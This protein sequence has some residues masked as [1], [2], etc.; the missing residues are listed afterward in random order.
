MI[1]SELSQKTFS[2]RTKN[3][4]FYLTIVAFWCVIIIPTVLYSDIFPLDNEGIFNIGENFQHWL[5][6]IA[7]PYNG[8]GR[9][10]PIFWI[11]WSSQ[12][13]IFAQNIG[14]YLLVQGIFFLLG[15]IFFTN[16]LKRASSSKLAALTFSCFAIFSVPVAENITSIGKAEPLT[17]FFIGGLLLLFFNSTISNQ[18]ITLS[19]GLLIASLMLLS[20]W[21][22][23]TSYALLGFCISGTLLSITLLKTTKNAFYLNQIKSYSVFFLYLSL[24][25]IA[26][27]TPYFLFSDKTHSA[28]PADGLSTAYTSYDITTKI[29]IENFT[30]YLLQQ[31]TVFFSLLISGALC[32]SL[33]YKALKDKSSTPDVNAVFFISLYSLGMAFYLALLIWRWAMPY[34]MLLPAIIFNLCMFY[35]LTKVPL[36][37]FKLSLF[38]KLFLTISLAWSLLQTYYIASSQIDYSRLYAKAI[39]YYRAHAKPGQKLIIES[40]PFYAQQV[41]ATITLLDV[42]S[43]RYGDVSGIADL[44]DP[45]VYNPELGKLLGVTQK[46]LDDNFRNLPKKGDF[47]LVFTGEKLATWFLRGVTP[48][49]APDSILHKDNMYDMT[50]VDSGELD[51]LAIFQHVWFKNLEFDNT[52]LGYK[53]Y[54]IDSK[55]YKY[56]WRDRYPDGWSTKDSELLLSPDFKSPV[57]VRL[58]APSYNLPNKVTIY[59]NHGKLTT[60]D[61]ND[62][63]EKTLSLGLAPTEFESY[64]FSVERTV[65]PLELKINKDK[66]DIGVRLELIR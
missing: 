26:S 15:V 32:A 38:L 10:F 25:A 57:V 63:S 1:N 50:L 4:G 23:E 20:I 16:L 48:Y 65:S 5:P 31:P 42:K 24:G 41:G 9:Y 28:A 21:T 3:F 58:S 45:A 29:I 12:Y 64:Q 60:V 39:T 55:V 47:L 66:R 8:S 18:R 22:K 62:S 14:G 52:K 36:K 37:K 27:R 54:R 7:S 40:Y 35:G 61:L 2:S 59:K 34:Y 46:D 17:V 44:L 6:W 49:Y 53:I 11:F 56:F 43:P 30:F 19:R 33:F 51:R 13:Q